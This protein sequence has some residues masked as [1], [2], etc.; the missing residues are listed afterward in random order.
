MAKFMDVH[1]GF[2]GVTDDR[3]C[4]AHKRP[5]RRGLRGRALRARMAR[6]TALEL[7][8]CGRVR[9]TAS[10]FRAGHLLLDSLTHS[11]QLELEIQAL[12]GAMR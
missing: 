10:Y 1:S 6:P 2:A 8:P 11:L 3:L 5:G 7:I 9:A 12:D 4:Q